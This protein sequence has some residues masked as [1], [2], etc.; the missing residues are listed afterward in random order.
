ML[1]RSCNKDIINPEQNQK[2]PHCGNSINNEADISEIYS[3]S[4]QPWAR[5]IARIFDLQLFYIFLVFISFLLEPIIPVFLDIMQLPV[6]VLFVLLLWVLVES[7]LLTNFGTTLGKK[8]AGLRIIHRTEM[9]PSFNHYFKR[10]FGVY[11]MGVG[12]GLPFIDLI[13]MFISYRTLVEHKITV[14]DKNND[15]Q[16]I[17]EKNNRK[18]VINLIIF[19]LMVYFTTL[20]L[21]SLD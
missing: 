18:K 12:L 1:C 2:C 11:F 4:P 19:V 3:D 20:I 16:V 13:A 10:S 17:H 6:G 9:Y 8:L 15:F 7:A 14:W 21:V 5:F